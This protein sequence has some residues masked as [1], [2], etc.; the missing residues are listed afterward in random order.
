MACVAAAGAAAAELGLR[1]GL[2]VDDDRL[3][4]PGLEDQG[5][6]WAWELG[7]GL[8]GGQSW[9]EMLFPRAPYPVD[10]RP[11][12]GAQGHVHSKAHILLSD[13]AAAAV[14]EDVVHEVGHHHPHYH[15]VVSAGCGLGDSSQWIVVAWACFAL[16]HVAVVAMGCRWPPGAAAWVAPVVVVGAPPVRA[17][18]LRLCP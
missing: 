7:R 17:R 1:V 3:H 2:G 4:G 5:E 8:S 6:P 12:A 11:L 14:E 9:A 18:V 10:C 16:P 13:A 15:L